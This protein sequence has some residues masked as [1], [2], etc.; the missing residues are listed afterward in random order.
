M[1]QVFDSYLFISATKKEHCRDNT[2][3]NRDSFSHCVF[4][5][6]RG[7]VGFIAALAAL[8]FGVSDVFALHFLFGSEFQLDIFIAPFIVF[9]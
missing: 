9:T 2:N 3:H 1:S 8:V 4:R 7:G 6:N 5:W